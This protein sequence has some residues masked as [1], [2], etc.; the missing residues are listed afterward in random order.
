M[1]KIGMIGPDF[2][3]R[4]NAEFFQQQQIKSFALQQKKQ[5]AQMDGLLITGWKRS[6]YLQQLQ[7]LQPELCQRA[8]Q[9]SLLGIAAG[10]VTLGRQDFFSLMDCRITLQAAR[11]V[12]TA[13][14]EMPGYT[15]N[16]FTA[17]FL[18]EVRFHQLAPN[19]G[20]LCQHQKYGPIMVRQGN[21]LACSYV[22][23]LTPQPYL[24]HYWL[25]MVAALKN[26]Q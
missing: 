14:L 8:M 24:Y 1:L 19:L 18:P 5:L 4:R 25:E 11:S 16:R 7:Q 3:L 9:I 2:L 12:T 23:E 22:A 15:D 13:V 6:D 20:V 17:A 26:S 10:A 21:H